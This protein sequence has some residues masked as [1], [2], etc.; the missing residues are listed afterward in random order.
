M[1]NINEV[2]IKSLDL[3]TYTETKF[4]KDYDDIIRGYNQLMSSKFYACREH[5]F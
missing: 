4:S 3:I 2:K 5:F 1:S